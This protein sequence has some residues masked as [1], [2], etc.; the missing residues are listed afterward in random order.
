[1]NAAA[2]VVD[3][4]AGSTGSRRTRSPPPRGPPRPADTPA[5]ISSRWCCPPDNPPWPA[6][7]PEPARTA[8]PGVDLSRA[9]GMPTT[10]GS[11]RPAVAALRAERAGLLGHPHHASWV[12]EIDTADTVEAVSAMLA[13][14]VAARGPQRRGRGRR[15]ATRAG[16]P[17]EPWDRAF[18][19]EQVRREREVDDRRAASVPRAG[20]GAA[21]RGVRTRRASCTGCVSPSATICPSTTRTCAC[22]T[23]TVESGEPV[24]LF[25]ADH[26][27]RPTKRGGAW[28]NSFVEQSRLLGTRPVVLNT[29]NLTK[30]AAG[31]PTL[32][33]VA[34]VVHALPRVRPRPARAA[35]GRALPD[36]R[37]HGRAARLRRVPLAGQRGVV[38]RS[39]GG[40]ALCPA[41][42]H[43]R[44]AAGRRCATG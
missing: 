23:C 18:Y 10:P 19:T 21:R 35:L 38:A 1:M 7:G 28:M 31:E 36:V 22:S 29:L 26:Y 3:E 41:P 44:A 2:V 6:D 9:A 34:E 30:P 17:L 25:V 33:T 43:R 39:V 14:L 4:P 8:V 12:I 42:R 24:G 37:R 11:G 27:A 32:L 40:D 15:A 16:H 20:A 13:A 5:G